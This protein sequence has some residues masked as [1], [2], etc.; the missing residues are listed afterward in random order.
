MK[1]DQLFIKNTNWMLFLINYDPKNMGQM[2]QSGS[3]DPNF[4]GQLGQVRVRW[5]KFCGSG[6]SSQGQV[7][8]ILWVSWVKSGSGDPNFVGQVGQVRVRWPIFGG[9]NGS[10]R[11]TQSTHSDSSK[12]LQ[13]TGSKCLFMAPVFFKIKI[14]FVS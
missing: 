14:F 5:P 13:K 6:G 10:S 8:Q 4:V 11:M 7:T 12:T 2:G 3:G 9:S 1:K